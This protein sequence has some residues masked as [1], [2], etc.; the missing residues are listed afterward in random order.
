M[1]ITATAVDAAIDAYQAALPKWCHSTNEYH[2]NV[3]LL[4][5]HQRD[6]RIAMQAALMAALQNNPE[7]T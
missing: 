6:L 4:P 1:K 2:R 7:S 5:G 3:F